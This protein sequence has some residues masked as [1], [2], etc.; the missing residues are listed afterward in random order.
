MN[1]G[2]NNRSYKISIIQN[3]SYI[4]SCS[5]IRTVRVYTIAMLKHVCD[6]LKQR[7]TAGAKSSLYERCTIAI[8]KH[9][10]HVLKQRQARLR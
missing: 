8:L 2:F 4:V 6:V 10:C 3:I 9:V 1:N 7:Q 5:Q